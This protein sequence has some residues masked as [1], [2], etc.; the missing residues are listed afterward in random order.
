MGKKAIAICEPII[1]PEKRNLLS[2]WEGF[3]IWYDLVQLGG[4]LL[5]VSVIKHILTTISS[6]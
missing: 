1:F 6:G 4:D 5:S 3:N 2:K